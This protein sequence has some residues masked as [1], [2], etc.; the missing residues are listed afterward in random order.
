LRRLHRDEAGEQNMS[1]VMLLGLG[2]LVV[3][4]LIAIGVIIFNYARTSIPKATNQD[5]F[6]EG[7]K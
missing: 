4:G 3:V 7:K 2:A 1:T 6:P 5:P